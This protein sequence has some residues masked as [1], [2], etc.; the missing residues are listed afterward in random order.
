LQ[1]LASVR[2]ETDWQRAQAAEMA[3][4]AALDINTPLPAPIDEHRA[5]MLAE[6]VRESEI[7][8]AQHA[9]KQSGTHAE[10]AAKQ[11]ELTDAIRGEAIEQIPSAISKAAQDIAR[12]LAMGGGA[13]GNV[14]N[15]S[16]SDQPGLAIVTILVPI[17]KADPWQTQLDAL[18]SRAP[19]A[20]IEHFKALKNE[21]DTTA[22]Q[23][24]KREHE[25]WAVRFEREREIACSP[26]RWAG[27]NTPKKFADQFRQQA[28]GSL[29][30]QL[31]EEAKRRAEMGLDPVHHDAGVILE[32][33]AHKL[34]G[35]EAFIPERH[36]VPEMTRV[37][38]VDL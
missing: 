19:K 3:V 28:S 1:E 32:T 14:I 9:R 6:R 10:V 25:Q 21:R 34:Y 23:A 5:R 15:I 7:A 13:G 17:Q 37:R 20:V 12:V 33:Y 16:E 4:K 18:G 11:K 35:T 8:M 26:L 29:G 30:Q 36:T 31:R 38:G 2:K 24:R 27:P 22:A